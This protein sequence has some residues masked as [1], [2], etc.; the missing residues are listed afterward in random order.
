MYT[1][2]GAYRN[3]FLEETAPHLYPLVLLWLLAIGVFWFGHSWFY[4]MKKSFADLI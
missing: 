3:I 4:K 1:V 2:V